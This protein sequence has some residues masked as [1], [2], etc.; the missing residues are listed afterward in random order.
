VVLITTVLRFGG[1]RTFARGSRCMGW[2]G[3]SALGTVDEEAE[4][5]EI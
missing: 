3:H 1:R 5:E 4:Y 2:N